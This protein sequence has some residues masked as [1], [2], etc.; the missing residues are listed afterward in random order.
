MGLADFVKNK[1]QSAPNWM[2]LPLL[3]LNHFGDKVY[4][5]RTIDFK[6]NIPDLDPDKMLIEMANYAIAH[7]PY[8]NKRYSGLKIRTVEDFTSNISFI[9]KKE[10]VE[11]FDEFISDE[12]DNIPH[13]TLATSGTSGKPLHILMPSDRYVTEMAFIGRILEHTGW[14]YGTKASI[15]R[16]RLPTSRDYMVN[17]VTKE[18]IFDGYRTDIKY[19]EKMLKVIKKNNVDTLYGYPSTIAQILH[20]LKDNGMDISFIKRA[21]LTSE[22]VTRMDYSFIKDELGIKIA[23]YY[24]HTE[25]LILLEQ[26]DRNKFAIEPGYGFTE[27]IGQDNKQVKPGEA[28]ELVG[29]TFYN[30]V[31]PLLRYRTGDYAV[32]TGETAMIDG[33]MKPIVGEI[34]GRREKSI[35]YRIDGSH[36]TAAAFEIHDEHK[37]TFEAI[38]YIQEKRGYLKVLVVKGKN[39]NPDDEKFMLDHYGY[40]MLGRQYVELEFV[41]KLVTMPNGKTLTVINHTI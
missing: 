25:K 2:T 29:T 21:I 20:L 19:L 39:F 34:S 12:A 16:K 4:G 17:P 15:R 32:P 30:R 26:I 14:E 36:T 18:I 33:I 22:P 40:A 38:Q 8:Y 41:D 23:T 27:I 11:H 31:M 3:H 28:G 9:D 6:H 37:M 10:V 35:I 13:V 5:K 24:G 7:V 1:I